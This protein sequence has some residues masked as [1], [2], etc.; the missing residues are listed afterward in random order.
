MVRIH[1]TKC[2]VAFSGQIL[3]FRYGKVLWNI[4]LN[5]I[6][7]ALLGTLIDSYITSTSNQS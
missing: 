1:L 4:N 5:D 3:D 6:T 7:F 2:G